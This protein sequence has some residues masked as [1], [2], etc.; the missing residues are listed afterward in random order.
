MMR[1]EIKRKRVSLINILIHVAPW[2]IL[3]VLNYLFIRNYAV[4]YDFLFHANIWLIYIAL[5]YLNYYLLIPA[6]LFN[7]KYISYILIILVTISVLGILKNEIEFMLVKKNM[8]PTGNLTFSLNKKGPEPPPDMLLPDEKHHDPMMNM[9]PPGEKRP[10]FKKIHRMPLGK[11]MIFRFTGLLLIYM[12]ST[13]I[14]FIQKWRDDEKRRNEI[15]KEKIT[16]ELSFLKQQ[17]NPHFLF[18]SLNSI[19]SLSMNKSSTTTDAILKLSSILRYMLYETDKNMVLLNQEL[20][21][22]ENYIELQ[23][24]RLTDKVKVEYKINGNPDNYKI[25]PLLLIPLVENA[26][27]YGTDNQNESFINIEVKLKENKFELVVRNKIV[28]NQKNNS[29]FEEGGIGIQNIKRRLEL[30]YENEHTLMNESQDGV[31][32]VNLHLNLKK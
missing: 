30:I 3:F 1:T 10:D 18:N 27:K 13:S 32:T 9:P 26:F 11:F 4:K 5:F 6:L 19:Y 17:I 16:N 21:V 28:I 15:E 2:I 25:P 20:E 31:Y 29:M 24:M 22:L 14:R 8:A 12:G 23:S 7:K